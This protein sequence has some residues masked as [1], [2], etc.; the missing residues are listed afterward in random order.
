MD[1]SDFT[2][3]QLMVMYSHGLEEAFDKLFLRHCKGLYKYLNRMLGDKNEAEDIL[4]ETFIRVAQNAGKYESTDA[5][6]AWLY[7]IA[8]NRCLSHLKKRG[9]LKLLPF[10]RDLPEESSEP[11]Q[12][13]RDREVNEAFKK[14]IVDLDPLLRAA[15]VLRELEH[16][17]YPEA[18]AI[19]DIPVGTVKTNVHRGKIILRKK[20]ARHFRE[21]VADGL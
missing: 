9:R 6:K 7:R 1:Y 11:F 5:F 2:D 4:Q 18:A 15:V 20:L 3:C 13:A 12:Q 14:A 19:L 16:Y 17:T 8:T 21:D 10:P